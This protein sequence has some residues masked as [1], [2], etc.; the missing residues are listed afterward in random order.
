L[1]AANTEV[2]NVKTAAV[3]YLAE[4]GDWPATSGDLDDFLEGGSDA[5]QATYTFYNPEDDPGE[6]G[7][8]S[9]ADPIDGGWSGIYWN[10]DD[11]IWERGEAPAP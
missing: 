10:P 11:Q 7:R 1:N 2:Q 4:N 9:D 8:I 3:G 5:L 6:G